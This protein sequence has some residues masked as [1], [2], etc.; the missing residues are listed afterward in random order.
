MKRKLVKF[1][2]TLTLVAAIAISSTMEAKAVPPTVV[3]LI[4]SPEALIKMG[5]ELGLLKSTMTVEEFNPSKKASHDFISKL[6]YG[7][8]KGKTTSAS[9]A[10]EFIFDQYFAAVE[11][12]TSLAGRLLKDGTE[13]KYKKYSST[14]TASYAWAG[15]TISMVK[16]QGYGDEIWETKL[17][18]L[19]TSVRKNWKSY[20][21]GSKMTRIEA[22]DFV[23]EALCDKELDVKLLIPRPTPTPYY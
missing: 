7:A 17:S 23:I 4:E 14:G 1:L 11:K 3:Y 6:C 19:R 21:T 15:V 13:G 20:R 9:K 8:V 2:T 22:L 12:D 18:N 5:K 16:F 10:R